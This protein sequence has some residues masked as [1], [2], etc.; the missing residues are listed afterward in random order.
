MG[1]SSQNCFD[2]ITLLRLIKDE[3]KT[4]E[5]KKESLND[6]VE[7]QENFI[8]ELE[9]SFWIIG[10]E[11]C[12]HSAKTIPKGNEKNELQTV[13]SIVRVNPP[14]CLLVIGD[15]PIPP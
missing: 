8:N 5:L 7:M 9:L 1:D 3:I 13:K 14:Q 11:L 12:R 15:K 6:K 4:L 2:W 10:N